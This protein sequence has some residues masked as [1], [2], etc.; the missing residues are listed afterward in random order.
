MYD[1]LSYAVEAE[2]NSNDE[3]NIHNQ[4]KKKNKSRNF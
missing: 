3:M 2:V 1:E 4:S